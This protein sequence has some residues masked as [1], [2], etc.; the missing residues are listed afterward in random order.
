MSVL[1][2]TVLAGIGAVRL[3]QQGASKLLDELKREGEEDHS[4][5]KEKLLQYVEKAEQSGSEFK[6]KFSETSTRA[7]DN[8]S[9]WTKKIDLATKTELR[10]LEAKVSQLS[11]MVERLTRDL[12]GQQ[13]GHTQDQ[14]PAPNTPPTGQPM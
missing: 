13:P 9:D 4:Q 14:G 7:R 1:R 2:D 11:E 8:V 6:Q 5:T 3:A 10:S 12:G